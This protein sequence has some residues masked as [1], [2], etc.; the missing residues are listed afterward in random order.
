MKVLQLTFHCALNYGAVLQTYAL[1][2]VLRSMGH[3]V[4][5]IDLR[6]AALTEGY[7]LHPLGLI[8]RWHFARF[9]RRFCPPLTAAVRRPGQLERIAEAADAC[10]VGSDQVWNTGIT[11]VFA[12]DYFLDFPA[13]GC[14]KIAYAASFGS[15]HNDWRRDEKDLLR[16]RLASF[17]GISVREASAVRSL[18]ELGV[19]NVTRTL[20]PTLLLGD[21]SE[22]LP[23]APR[24][25]RDLLCMVFEPETGFLQPALAMAEQLSLTPTVLARE[26]PDPRIHAVPRPAVI[27]WV[28][29]F[30]DAAFILTNSFHGLA[31]ALIFNKPFAVVPGNADR[32]C[33][34]GELLSL[35]GLE[36]RAFGSYAELLTSQRWR[37]AVP[38]DRVNTVLAGLRRQSMAFLD[39]QLGSHGRRVRA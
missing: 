37:E 1:G 19:V 35:L 36:D 20:D 16:R 5:L 11:G 39:V 4:L 6:P 25:R 28:R 10:V 12:A 13:R 21:L 18:T 23:E 8:K 17:R 9:V 22:L 31:M 2:Q 26:A 30:R 33:R 32:F 29:C 38:Y 7:T 15:E 3:R 34:L 14:R 24:P 27:E